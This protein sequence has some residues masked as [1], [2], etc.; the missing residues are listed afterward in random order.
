MPQFTIQ[1]VNVTSTTKGR[2]TY[3]TAEVVY[4]TGRGE[5][6]TKKVMSFSNPAVFKTVKTLKQGD[7]V[8]V[9]YTEGDQYYSWSSVK[10]VGGADVVAQ[11]ASAGKVVPGAPVRVAGSNYETAEERKI[12]QLYIIKQSAINAAVASLTP[13]A[14]ASLD[15]GAVLERAQDYVDF[16]YG[17]EDL[18]DKPNDLP[19]EENT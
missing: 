13:G 18:F 15:L 10:L 14:K 19:M 2:N 7:E 11:N 12:K 5:Q 16:V 4:T 3:E 17:T 1:E 8:E 6:K 9:A